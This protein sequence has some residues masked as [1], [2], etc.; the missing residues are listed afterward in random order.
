MKEEDEL[1]VF[2]LM[3]RASPMPEEGGGEIQL[4]KVV[5]RGSIMMTGGIVTSWQQQQG[6]LAVSS[7]CVSNVVIKHFQGDRY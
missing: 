3:A 5:S 1:K 7:S 2:P 6:K 4:S